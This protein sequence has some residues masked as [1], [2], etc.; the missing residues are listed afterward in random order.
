MKSIKFILPAL[1][2]LLVSANSAQAHYDPNLGRWVNRD[3]IEEAGG[4]NLYG[5]VENNS[6]SNIDVLGL[7]GQL[8]F[9]SQGLEKGN[10]GNFRWDIEWLPS[11]DL[12]K[13][14]VIFQEVKFTI[15]K[16]DCEETGRPIIPSV[17]VKKE[18]WTI[19][20]SSTRDTWSMEDQG[21]TKG[22]IQVEAKA[23]IVDSRRLNGPY[24]PN[25]PVPNPGDMNNNPLLQMGLIGSASHMLPDEL[26]PQMR[27]PRP[28]TSN[29]IFRSLSGSWD[30]CNGKEKT[31]ASAR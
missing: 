9:K 1:I 5:F 29:V 23:Y 18:T 7:A 4:E 16:Y 6:V 8:D 27:N 31:Q 14:D 20:E 13:G 24:N 26:A 30:C 10:C 22:Y 2:H 11:G 17:V 19:G 3:P 28:S 25:P 12:F 15:T 21:C